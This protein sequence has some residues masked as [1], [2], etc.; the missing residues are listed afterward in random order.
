MAGIIRRI[1]E[2]GRIVLPKEMRKVLNL[3][4]GDAL[5]IS[6][7][8][9]EI[10][11]KKYLPLS[12]NIN[13]ILEIAKNL[14]AATDGSVLITDCEAV[15]VAEGKLSFLKGEKLTLNALEIIKNKSSFSLSKRDGAKPVKITNNSEEDS[16]SQLIM[17]IF[18]GES[19]AYGLVIICGFIEE[20]NYDATD[21]K[22]LKFVTQML[23]SY[24]KTE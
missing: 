21:I 23:Y 11:V 5:E 20:K 1:D 9:S 12:K 4:T 6:L 14:R 8:G 22:L 13:E 10:S 15:I 17:P 3:T 16:F 18:S 2:L 24:F 19:N 7:N